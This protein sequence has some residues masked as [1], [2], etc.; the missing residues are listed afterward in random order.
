MKPDRINYP[1]W[2]IDYLDGNLDAYQTGQLI[3][4]LKQNPDLMD[5]FGELVKLNLNPRRSFFQHKEQL[6][7]TFSDLSNSQFEYLCVANSENDLSEQES[8]ELKEIIANNE[9]KK[10]TYELICKLKL[11]A[12]SVKFSG[13]ARLRKLTYTKKI[14]RLSFI[15]LSAAASLALLFSLFVLLPKI[16]PK[17]R[18]VTAVISSKKTGQMKDNGI[19]IPGDTKNGNNNPGPESDP[20]NV[21]SNVQKKISDEMKSFPKVIYAIDTTL[22]NAGIQHIKISKIG[23]IQKVNLLEDPHEIALATVNMAAVKTSVDIEETRFNA[24]IAKTFRSK[25]LKSKSIENGPLK[26]YEIADAGITGLN[27]ILGW[28]MSLQ[29]NKDGKGELKSVYFSSKI[30]KFNAPVKKLN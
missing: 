29:Q 4:F 20:G 6:K 27:K 1:I 24:F 7:K 18:N 10:R 17:N 5:E 23:F 16:Q 14:V 15:G 25:I 13:K 8:K 2:L 3:M 21:L 12:P 11:I 28:Q 9:E 26:A 22:T 30:L 19:R